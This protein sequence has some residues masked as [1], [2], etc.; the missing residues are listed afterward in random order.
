MSPGLDLEALT[1]RVEQSAPKARVGVRVRSPSLR[2]SSTGSRKAETQPS[3]R[4]LTVTQG[5][6]DQCRVAVGPP[7]EHRCGSAACR[8]RQT[9]TS[10]TGPR[11]DSSQVGRE[12]LQPAD[13]GATCSRSSS[14]QSYD[15]R[16]VSAHHLA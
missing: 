7:M 5:A 14:G 8:P 15:V 10:E 4:R 12:T 3:K 9:A 1:A 2:R 11:A 16:N 13:Q 6:T